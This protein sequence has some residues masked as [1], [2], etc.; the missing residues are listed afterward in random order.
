MSLSNEITD[1]ILKMLADDGI[2]EISRNEFANEFGCVPSQINYVISSRFTP[3]HGYIVESQRGGG[4]YIRISRVTNDNLEY[5][6]DALNSAGN[7]I[8]EKMLKALVH[9]FYNS[10]FLNLKETRLILSALSDSTLKDAERK[11]R[12]KIRASIFKNMIMNI[13]DEEE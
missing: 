7:E 13:L 12:N 5:V 3:E 6:I 4:G 2:T 1:I 10:E 8:D 9:N 11:D